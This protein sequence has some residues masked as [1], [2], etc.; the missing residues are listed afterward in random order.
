[1]SRGRD[2]AVTIPAPMLT[3]A[4]V[5]AEQSRRLRTFP[6]EPVRHSAS[7]SHR[8]NPRLGT[9]TEVMDVYN[10]GKDTDR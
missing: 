10:P 6:P 5:S 3:D 4:E 2:T 7:S 9:I 8:V 1:V